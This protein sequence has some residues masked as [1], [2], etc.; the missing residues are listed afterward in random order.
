MDPVK[1]VADFLRDN[2]GHLTRPGNASYDVPSQ[3][4]FVP[5]CVKS[6]RGDV[7][8]GDVEVDGDGHIV[9]APSREEVVARFEAHQQQA[10]QATTT[11]AG[12]SA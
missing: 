6:G 12:A 7:V 11:D 10:S 2:M 3:R 9:Y 5:I 4:W 8:V 1:R